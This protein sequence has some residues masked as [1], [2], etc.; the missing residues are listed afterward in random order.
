MAPQQNAQD[1]ESVLLSVFAS[2]PDGSA[3]PSAQSV[4]KAARNFSRGS[5]GQWTYGEVGAVGS[6]VNKLGL[7]ASDVFCDLGSG[8]GRLALGAAMMRPSVCAKSIGVE[9]DENRHA[10]A[11]KAATMLG[12]VADACELRCE[13]MLTTALDNV[14]VA[15]CN[16]AVF[17]AE[18]NSEVAR[19]LRTERCGQLRLVVTTS[20]L[21]IM[22]ADAAGLKLQRI[23]VLPVNWA[24]SGHP[25]YFYGREGP[26]TG[27]VD[28]DPATEVM[29]ESMRS[30]C[31]NDPEMSNVGRDGCL[32]RIAA[33]A[34]QMQ[35][36]ATSWTAFYTR[37]SM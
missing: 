2:L 6:V 30:Q 3:S 11:T 21:P 29:V 16:N 8:R 9:L 10:I 15:F 7:V 26:T 22:A 14:S 32:T 4:T 24:S 1:A 27:A 23:S 28:V 20:P 18:L 19:A 13:D 34:C 37:E 36:E 33:F 5:T 31:I 17:G 12:T 35:T 25:S